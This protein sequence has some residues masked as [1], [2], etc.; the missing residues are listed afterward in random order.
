MSEGCKWI[1]VTECL[2]NLSHPNNRADV[3]AA[4]NGGVAEM[5]YCQFPDAK[6]ARGRAPRWEWQGRSSPWPVTHWMP[7]PEGPK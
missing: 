5:A 7:L 6:T 3:L 4:W 2:P 1:S